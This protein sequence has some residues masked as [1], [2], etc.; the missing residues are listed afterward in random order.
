MFGKMKKNSQIMAIISVC[1]LAL[2]FFFPLWK[3]DLWAP[4]Y[5]E[6]LGMQIWLTKMTGDLGNINLLN[7]YIG[8][9]KIEPDSIP[10]LKI[11]IYIFGGLS[12]LG[13]V[14]AVSGRRCL[15]HLFA[16][17]F[18]IFSVGALYDFYQWE[19]KYGHELS[20]D[21]AIKME[22]ESYQPPLIG[23]K[24]LMNIEAWSLP[25]PGGYGHI[26]A[27]V[28]IVTASVIEFSD[29]KKER[30]IKNA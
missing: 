22:G 10:E 26:F 23:K 7:H 18:L 15:L 14:V 13:T 8:M 24:E 29:A 30:K 27:L 11:F 3:I 9:Q 25:G 17:S 20:E 5:P 6:G 2:V 28:L 21:A 12:L 1:S 4:Q 19:Y 16:A